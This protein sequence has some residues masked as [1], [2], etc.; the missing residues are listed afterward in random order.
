MA[1]KAKAIKITINIDAANLATLKKEAE[2]TGIPYQRLLNQVLKEALSNR[3]SAE[4]RLEKL[5]REVA[6]MKRKLAA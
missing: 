4:A 1:A 5:E 2:L 3:E 6:Q